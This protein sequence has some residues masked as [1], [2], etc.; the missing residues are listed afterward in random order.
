MMAALVNANNDGSNITID[1]FTDVE[2][3]SEELE[4]L[5]ILT[6]TREKQVSKQASKQTNK[7]TNK[8]NKQTSKQANKRTN[9]Q[10]QQQQTP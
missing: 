7:Q 2:L 3:C 6:E 10:Q 1:M 8:T 4:R 9:K 5:E